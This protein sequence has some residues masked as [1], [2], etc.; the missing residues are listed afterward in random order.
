MRATCWEG[1]Q[2]VKV[3]DVPEPRILNDRDA[4]VRVTSTAICG[5]DLHLYNGFV[6][7]MMKATSS[8]TSSW[9]RS[10]KSERA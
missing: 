3:E 9:A 10:W 1:K 6:P 7:T 4:I 2:K 5:S 8:A